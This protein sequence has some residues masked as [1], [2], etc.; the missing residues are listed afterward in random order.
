MDNKIKNR[1]VKINTYQKQVKK[2]TLECN[3]ICIAKIK[4]SGYI[5]KYIAKQ[6]RITEQNFS[7][8]VSHKTFTISD[9]ELIYKFL[10]E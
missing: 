8:K 10:D 5:Q 2:M 4:N 3:E 7:H 1:I 9:I 6:I